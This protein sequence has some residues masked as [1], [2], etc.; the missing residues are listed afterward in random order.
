MNSTMFF[1]KLSPMMPQAPARRRSLREGVNQSEMD[2]QFT[3][4]Q[5]QELRLSR[6]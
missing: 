4:I 1:G 2:S 5:P 6:N 3:T